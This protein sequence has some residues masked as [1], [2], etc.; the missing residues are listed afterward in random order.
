VSAATDWSFTTATGTA[1]QLHDR[2]RPNP[3]RRA[4]VVAHPI[5]RAVVLGSTQAA[6]DPELVPAAA[7]VTRRTSGGGAVWVAPGELV[8]VDVD[9]P[10]DD[11]LWDDDVGRS[12]LWL[13]RAWADALKK[14]G[15][16]GASI[17]ES[18]LRCGPAGRALCFAG[19]G[20]GEVSVAGRKV[21]GISQRRTR[22]GTRFHCAALL[23]WSP[24]LL[25]RTMGVPESLWPGLPELAAG[26]EVKPDELVAAFLEA[27]PR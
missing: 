1:Q 3:M 21:V 7:A 18:G 19:V 26:L 12:F 9:L 10:A 17:W 25:A 24:L 23:K 11:R 4:V 27:L 16:G 13:G 5:G 22:E 2:I 8:W 20:P 14:V 6:P 15:V